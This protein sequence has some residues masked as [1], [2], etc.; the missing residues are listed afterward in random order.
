MTAAQPGGVTVRLP[1]VLADLASGRRRLDVVPSPT[2]VGGLLDVLSLDYPVLVRRVRDES[3]AVRRF[4]NVYVDG[5]DIRHLDGL[6][7]PVRA[8]SDV[9]ILP[10]V[11]GG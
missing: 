9:Q 11:A 5:E 1:S 3:D 7:T 8:G 4:V 2:T 6:A 10:S